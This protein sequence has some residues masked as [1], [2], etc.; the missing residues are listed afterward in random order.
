MKVSVVICTYNRESYLKLCLEGLFKNNEDRSLYEVIV[1]DN[2]STDNTRQIVES[3]KV[4][5]E[6]RYVY[7]ERV[8]LSNARN[9]GINEANYDIIAYLDDD[10]IPEK[11]YIN[12][13]ICGF[14]EHQVKCGGGKIIPIWTV[15]KPQWYSEQFNGV[16]TILDCGDKD[17]VLDIDYPYGANMFF[18]KSELIKVGGFNTELGLKGN[19]I[20]MGEDDD[21]FIRFKNKGHK[22]WYLSQVAVKHH[23][24]E[25]K[26]NKEYVKK[27]FE[28]GGE[29]L[30]KSYSISKSGNEFT[31]EYYRWVV[32]YLFK[33]IPL[34]NA[35]K[36]IKRNKFEKECLVLLNKGF[37]NTCRKIK[38]KEKGEI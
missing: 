21:M 26:I 6:I 15:D 35:S 19:E 29:A 23:V 24:P 20:I 38:I 12:N 34:Y 30:A 28:A 32:K 37:I 5:E 31:Y 9:R 8:G 33:I 3:F 27:R 36:I 11:G 4:N 17:K 2:K 25:G 13:I 1:I 22:I 16:F 18:L 10:A 14:N 7:E